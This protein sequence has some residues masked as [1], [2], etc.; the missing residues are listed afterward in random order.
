VPRITL[1]VPEESLWFVEELDVWEE[2]NVLE[3]FEFLRKLF[4]CETQTLA[5]AGED[6]FRGLFF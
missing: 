2:M 4:V 3:S 5:G 6:C 1:D